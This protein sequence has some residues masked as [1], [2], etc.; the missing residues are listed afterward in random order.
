MPLQQHFGG[1]GRVFKPVV[2]L[3]HK[4]VHQARLD[5]KIR[6]KEQDLGRAIVF[7]EVSKSL[8]ARQRV[9]LALGLPNVNLGPNSC[10]IVG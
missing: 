1:P 6:Q 5:R 8:R 2:D 7:P 9:A 10:A 4:M 3:N